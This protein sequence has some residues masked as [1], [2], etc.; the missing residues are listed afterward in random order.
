MGNNRKQPQQH[1][2]NEKKRKKNKIQETHIPV[3][4]LKIGELVHIAFGAL[5]LMVFQSEFLSFLPCI[6]TISI[7]SRAGCA[8][9]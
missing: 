8:V 5:F 4:Q 3:L 7:I 2:K 9:M 1:F 6:R